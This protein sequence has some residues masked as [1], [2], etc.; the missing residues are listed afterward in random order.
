LTHQL[1]VISAHFIVGVNLIEL[2]DTIYSALTHSSR[3]N[4][5][6]FKTFFHGVLIYCRT[7]SEVCEV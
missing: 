1:F 2:R 3:F 5:K 6:I 4:E 7:T